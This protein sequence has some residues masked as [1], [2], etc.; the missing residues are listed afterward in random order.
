MTLNKPYTTTADQ[1]IAWAQLG[2]MRRAE[3]ARELVREHHYTPQA[4]ARATV[5]QP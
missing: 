4:A 5:I 2:V 1:L 3:A